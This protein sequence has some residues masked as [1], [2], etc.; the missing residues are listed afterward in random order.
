MKRILGMIL[1]VGI[2]GCVASASQARDNVRVT[3][4]SGALHAVKECSQYTGLAGSF[5]TITASNLK[6]LAPGSKVIYATSADATSLD[7][8]FVIDMGHGT[9]AHGHVLLSF[10]TAS[11]EIT[12]NGGTGLMRGFHARAAVSFDGAFWHWDG[13]YWFS[14]PTREDNDNT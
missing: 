5:C 11:G 1:A 7:S 2:A 14:P 8:D 3:P 10:V 4:R 9:T 6:A 12:I 13:T